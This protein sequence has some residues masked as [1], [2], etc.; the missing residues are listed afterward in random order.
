M[1]AYRGMSLPVVVL[2]AFALI[3]CGGGSSNASSN[4]Q[5]APAPTGP[6]TNASFSGQYAFMVTGANTSGFFALAGS[7][8][9]DGNGNIVS[10]VEDVNSAGGTFSS[11]P[12]T[13]TYS[14]SA[15]GRGVAVLTPTNGSFN[16]VTLD[17]VLISSQRALVTRFDTVA[18]ASGTLDLQNST[19]FSASALSGQFAFNL[20]GVDSTVAPLQTVGMWQSDGASKLSNGTLDTNDNGTFSTTSLTGSYT[21]GSSNGRGIATLNTSPFGTISVVFY[22]VDQYRLRLVGANSTPLLAGSAYSQQGLSNVA[23]GSYAYTV[24]GGTTA[25][26]PYVAGGVFT[27][28]NSGT[29]ATGVQD[30]NSNGSVQQNLSLTGLYTSTGSGRDALTLTTGVGT[31]NFVVYPSL[32]GQSQMRLLMLEK[33]STPISFGAAFPQQPVT[34]SNASIQGNFGYNLDGAFSNGVQTDAIAHLSADGNGGFSGALSTL[35]WNIGG[36]LWRGLLFEGNYA[37]ASNGRG[38]A[39]LQNGLGSSYTQDFVLYQVNSSQVLLIE[40]D[41]GLIAV[42]DMEYQ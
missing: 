30:S 1:A 34:Y 29:V 25:S 2:L 8:Q 28:N 18:S 27:I 26:G 32:Q 7:L 41:S 11:V 36:V 5:F 33:D 12:I 39:T 3:G 40:V 42:G 19:Y 23:P 6:F 37:M 17:F 10:G 35:D 21:V 38:T 13:G 20:S 22:I 14:V 16:G 31:T 15:D 24:A 4:V 9:A